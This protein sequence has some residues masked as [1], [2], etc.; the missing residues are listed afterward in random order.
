MALGAQS[1]SVVSMIVKDGMLVT[2]LGAAAGLTLN[3]WTS[4]FLV[5]L[6]YGVTPFDHAIL[7]AVVLLLL[8]VS[9]L[10]VYIPA[11]RAA[12]VDPVAALRE[13]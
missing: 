9:F 8:A 6:L 11:R 2:F 1:R 5:N 3:W 10:A 7:G 12:S 4:R 13:D